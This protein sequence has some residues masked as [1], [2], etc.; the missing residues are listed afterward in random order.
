MGGSDVLLSVRLSVILPLDWISESIIG[1]LRVNVQRSSVDRNAVVF[2]TAGR[3]Y[4]NSSCIFMQLG[5]P[6]VC[7]PVYLKFNHLQIYR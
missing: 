1:M 7:K 3:A 6:L 5:F 4:Y 2:R